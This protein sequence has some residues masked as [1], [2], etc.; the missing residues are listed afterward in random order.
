MDAKTR[1]KTSFLLSLLSTAIVG[2]EPPRVKL[3]V[4]VYDTAHI[5]SKTA[6][7]A[8][9]IAG[10]ILSTASIQS[11]W[12]AGPL[13]Q[14]G[15]LVVDFTAYAA[16][17][18]HADLGAAIVRLQ[19]VPHAPAGLPAQALG[20]SLPCARSGVQ[21]TIFADRVATV[22]ETAGP[23]F[24]R[25]LGYAMAHEV[26]HVLLQSDTHTTAGLMKGIWSKRDWQRAAVS[27]VSFSPA[28]VRQIAALH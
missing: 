27:V 11:S 2:Q 10:E 8:E 18:C 9:H 4:V 23:T 19:I 16:K 25:V 22:S 14:L 12:L 24:G 5:G 1:W 7:H 26:G 17:A 21:V 13:E 6:E 28:E 20:F 3:S 15:N